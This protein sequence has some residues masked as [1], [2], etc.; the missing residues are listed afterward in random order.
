[1]RLVDIGANLTSRQ[2]ASDLPAVIA[3]AHS[4]GVER[5]IVTGTSLDNSQQAATLATN[6]PGL[7]S[8]AGIHP[9]D[10]S[11]CTP[12]TL[13]AIE[14]L[15]AHDSVVALGECGLDFNRNYS[16]Q[17]VQLRVFEQQL[18]IAARTGLPAFLHQRDAH[19]EFLAI[20]RNAWP[21]LHGGAVVHC[22]T[23]GPDAAEDYL[24]L[25][26][27]LGITGWVC[28]ERRGGALRDA[29]RQIPAD[30]LLLETDAPYLLPRTIHPKPQPKWKTRRNEPM[31]LPWVVREVAQLRGEDESVVAANAWAATHAFFKLDP[32]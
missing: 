19:D 30:R 16:P 1:M 15:C 24:A 32:D 17:D 14:A 22:F 12:D 28:D 21:S 13:L 27:A 20:L 10:A 5:M 29:V 6:T 9:H 4:A 31:H 8:T 3:A 18:E 23:E 11:D 2:F 7:W 25:G 26:C